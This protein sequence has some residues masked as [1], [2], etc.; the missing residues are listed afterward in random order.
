MILKRLSRSF[1]EGK[2]LGYLSPD[3]WSLWHSTV[4]FDS[5]LVVLFIFD[6][7]TLIVMSSWR[8]GRMRHLSSSKLPAD[9]KY[10][11][12]MFARWFRCSLKSYLSPET[13]C[14][15]ICRGHV[16]DFLLEQHAIR[17]NFG[18]CPDGGSRLLHIS[19]SA[20]HTLHV[21]SG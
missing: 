18:I 17:L 12:W 5:T 10:L 15:L 6:F 7:M 4:D 11:P 13:L 19:W 20:A 3:C 14:V 2:I 8:R 21:S 16:L 1:R 9:Q